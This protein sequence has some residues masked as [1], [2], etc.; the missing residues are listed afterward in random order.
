MKQNN[1]IQNQLDT[2]E[3]DK[4]TTMQIMSSTSEKLGEF[5]KKHGL[6]NRDAAINAMLDILQ[7]EKR[8]VLA[9][10]FN[11]DMK[12]I[13]YEYYDAYIVKRLETGTTEVQYK[14][15]LFKLNTTEFTTI[16]KD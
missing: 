9:V 1:D 2:D 3:Q 12:V 14:S 10:L 7:F 16:Y 6:K 11:K 13:V 8:Q 5:T 4:K 15:D